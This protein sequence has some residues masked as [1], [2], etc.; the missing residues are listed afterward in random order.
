M[1]IHR[2]WIENSESI[3]FGL[4]IVNR[5][6]IENSESLSARCRDKPIHAL[7]KY[8]KETRI[9]SSFAYLF[10]SQTDKCVIQI[11]FH[12]NSQLC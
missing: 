5:I 1:Y 4:K 2:I 8:T 12:D 11:R 7:G 10:S 6:W 9:L 3:G